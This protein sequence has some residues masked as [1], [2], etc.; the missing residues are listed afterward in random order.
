MRRAGK[1][2]YYETYLFAV[3]GRGQIGGDYENMI[4]ASPFTPSCTAFSATVFPTRRIVSHCAHVRRVTNHY[5]LCTV[6]EKKHP[7]V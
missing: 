2:D 6:H 3:V 5:A 1:L 4:A 7:A